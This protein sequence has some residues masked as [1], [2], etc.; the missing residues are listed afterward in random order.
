MHLGFGST[1]TCIFP[2]ME[3]VVVKCCSVFV[4]SSLSRFL[5]EM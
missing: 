1:S 4:Y 2:F 3:I 5:V